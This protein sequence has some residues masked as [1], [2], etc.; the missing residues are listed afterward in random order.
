[1]APCVRHATFCVSGHSPIP[2]VYIGSV[3]HEAS[4]ENFRSPSALS[5]FLVTA[6]VGLFLDLW[7]KH[8]AFTKLASYDANGNLIANKVYDFIPTWLHF[9]VTTNHGAVFGLGAGQRA[10]FL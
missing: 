8:L 6:A 10:L 2:P 3:T 5:R 9:T 1:M 7:T 4:L